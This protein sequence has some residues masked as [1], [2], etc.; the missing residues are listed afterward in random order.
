M[1]LLGVVNLLIVLLLSP[2]YEGVLRKVKAIVHS[3]TGPPVYQPY[4]DILKLLG[5]EDLRVA[6]NLL[7]GLSP[8][9]A[10]ASIMM[11]GLMT[12]LGTLYPPLNNSS[13]IIVLIYFVS[14]FA[15]A[16][17]LGAAA[18]TSVYAFVGLNR[19][20]MLYLVL[21]IVMIIS[22]LTGVVRSGS[23]Q[24]SGIVA[25]QLNNGPTFSMVIGAISFFL[26]MQAQLAKLPFDIAEAEQ[27]IMGGPF[28]EASGPRLALFK[29][30]F[31]A[32]QIIYSSLFLELFIPWPKTH[33]LP[34]DII[35]NLVKVLIVMLFVG[36]I[37]V[38]NPRLKIDQ[39]LKYY[40]GVSIVALIGL[41]FAIIGA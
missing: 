20:M 38:V 41:A 14:L 13:D 28:I 31:Y 23:F 18:T 1:I 25:W 5:K 11:V 35:I 21:E 30:S 24:I 8:V 9:I 40:T 3:R 33:I 37:D 29:W 10:F 34:L 26:V 16:I 6:D 4:L 22:I 39:A 15:F 7:I 36:L 12:P 27:E 32:K 2:L 17:M 19:E